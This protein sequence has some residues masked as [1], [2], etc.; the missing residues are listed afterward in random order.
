MLCLPPQLQIFA[1]AIASG[2]AF[3]FT[4]TAAH[5]E[6]LRRRSHSSVYQK[7]YVKIVGKVLK[8]E[9]GNVPLACYRRTYNLYQT[10]RVTLIDVT[11]SVFIYV[12]TLDFSITVSKRILWIHSIWQA[13]IVYVIY[14]TVGRSIADIA[15]QPEVPYFPRREAP[16]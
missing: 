8:N 14:S 7:I 9:A 5:A 1:K 11:A 10:N 3:G 12:G 13:Y 4:A 2:Y 16:R 15:I 6:Y